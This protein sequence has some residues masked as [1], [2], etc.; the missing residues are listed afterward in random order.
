MI[1]EWKEN[2]SWITPDQARIIYK[3]QLDKTKQIIEQ[4]KNNQ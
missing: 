3:F 1:I 4:L 2:H